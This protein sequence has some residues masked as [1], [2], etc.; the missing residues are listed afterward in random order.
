[1]F[2]ISSSFNILGL[3]IPTLVDCKRIYLMLNIK[4]LLNR[5]NNNT[6]VGRLDVRDRIE[7]WRTSDTSCRFCPL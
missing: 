7:R 6:N 5:C 3:N 1:M 4:G 2:S